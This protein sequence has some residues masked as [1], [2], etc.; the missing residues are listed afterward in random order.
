MALLAIG[1]GKSNALWHLAD[2]PA[3]P[4]PLLL[5]LSPRFSYGEVGEEGAWKT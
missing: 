1:S 4:S 3:N 5:V 2:K